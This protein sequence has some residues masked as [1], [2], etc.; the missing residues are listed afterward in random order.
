MR[1]RHDRLADIHAVTFC[2]GDGLQYPLVIPRHHLGEMPLLPRPVGQYPLADSGIGR[3][4]VRLDGVVQVLD[5]IGVK[6]LEFDHLTV[7]VGRQFAVG[8]VDVGHTTGH[9]G[10]EVTAGAAEDDHLAAGHVLASVITDTLDHGVRPRV[11]DRESFADYAA[12]EYLPAGGAEQDDV[13]ADDVLLG[14]E[15]RRRIVRRPHHDPA[16]GQALTDVV[17]GV[18]VDAQRNTLGHKGA[19][20]VAGRAVKG[21]VNGTVR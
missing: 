17:V 4:D 2:F 11:S 12:Q 1:G 21:D 13:A 3:I 15:V 9:A 16:T 5:V 14:N 19:E 10:R 20:T 18:A 7:E 6:G 8:V